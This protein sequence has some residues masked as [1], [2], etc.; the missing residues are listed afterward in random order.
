M[1][2]P[3]FQDKIRCPS[4]ENLQSIGGKRISLPHRELEDVASVVDVLMSTGKGVAKKWCFL[5][6]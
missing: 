3:R 6:S 2:I 5:S 1:N 4:V